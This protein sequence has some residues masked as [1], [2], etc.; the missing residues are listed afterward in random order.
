MLKYAEALLMLTLLLL[1]NQIYVIHSMY[2]VLLILVG[3]A[4]NSIVIFMVNYIK[5]CKRGHKDWKSAAFRSI[6]IGWSID[7]AVLRQRGVY[8]DRK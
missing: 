8:N 5:S 7:E 6:I 3:Y 2:Y 4:N 1:I